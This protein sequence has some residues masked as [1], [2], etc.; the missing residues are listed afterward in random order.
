M[1]KN[2]TTIKIE[3]LSS[4][5]DPK[6]DELTPRIKLATGLSVTKKDAHRWRQED[7]IPDDIQYL[8]EDLKKAIWACGIPKG[9]KFPIQGGGQQAVMLCCRPWSKSF[10][11]R[12]VSLFTST[13]MRNSTQLVHNN[14]ALITE[15]TRIIRQILF[16]VNKIKI[17]PKWM[18]AK[19]PVFYQQQEQQRGGGDHDQEIEEKIEADPGEDEDDDL[20][21]TD[22]DEKLKQH[23][24]AD[25]DTKSKKEADDDDGDDDANND[26]E[27]QQ[28][29]HK[30]KHELELDD[31][32]EEDEDDDL[33]YVCTSIEELIQRNL[34]HV[35]FIRQMP[36]I[37]KNQADYRNVNY[38]RVSFYLTLCVYYDY[39]YLYKCKTCEIFSLKSKVK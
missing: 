13:W 14:T 1:P 12:F 17:P 33:I 36:K 31:E 25:D 10:S 4:Y 22:F 19:H 38:F 34:K 15:I 9:I 11:S 35:I 7:E 30:D 2:K 3:K 18:K 27:K 5:T 32:E 26:E 37:G 21:M 29:Q 23:K 20:D 28:Q 16:G 8:P 24:T 39:C 6:P